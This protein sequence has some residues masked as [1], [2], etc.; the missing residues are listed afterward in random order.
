VQWGWNR[1][2]A[3]PFGRQLGGFGVL[4][5]IMLV[6]IVGHIVWQ[7]LIRNRRRW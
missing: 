3:V 7:Y 1:G 6:L 2:A 5:S 4:W